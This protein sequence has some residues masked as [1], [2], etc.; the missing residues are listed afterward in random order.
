[1]NN[2]S[3]SDGGENLNQSVTRH[4]YGVKLEKYVYQK[5]RYFSFVI[6]AFKNYI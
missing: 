3:D 5:A 1:M 6:K 2:L 4:E